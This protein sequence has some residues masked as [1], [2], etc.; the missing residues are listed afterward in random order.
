MKLNK[1]DEIDSLIHGI[2]FMVNNNDHNVPEVF[3]YT[4][5]NEQ[6]GVKQVNSWAGALFTNQIAQSLYFKVF[7]RPNNCSSVS[8]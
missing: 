4:N 6:T 2:E 8:F 1:F 3:Y 5:L 7:C